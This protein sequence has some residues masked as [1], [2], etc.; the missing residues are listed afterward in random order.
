MGVVKPHR[1]WFPVRGEPGDRTVDQQMQGLMFLQQNVAGKTVLD[2]GCAEGLIDIELVKAGAVA[3]HGVELR[4]QA[5]A[6]ANELRGDM[7]ITFEQGDMNLWQPKRTYHVLV[8]LAILH[9]LKC[10]REVLHKLLQHCSDL[11]VLRLPPASDN[12][13]IR[14]ARS[15]STKR[16]IHLARTLAGAGFKLVHWTPGYLN[17]W[18]GYYRRQP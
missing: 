4:P 1:H 10:P 2:V 11:A 8:M 9:K 3:V 16:P 15:G 14:D 18:V 5:V 17:E 12:P 13:T 6:A 7:P